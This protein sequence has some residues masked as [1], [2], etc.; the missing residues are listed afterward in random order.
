MHELVERYRLSKQNTIVDQSAMPAE[1]FLPDGAFDFKSIWTD[2]L[3]FI[4]LEI[5]QH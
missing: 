1:L 2:K 5:V 3:N 4:A